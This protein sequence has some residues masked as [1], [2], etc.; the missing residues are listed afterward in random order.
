M[1]KLHIG[2]TYPSPPALRPGPAQATTILSTRPPWVVCLFSPAQFDSVDV[3]AL[4]PP[5]ISMRDM[6]AVICQPIPRTPA[7]HVTFYPYGQLLLFYLLHIFAGPAC[8]AQRSQL[9]GL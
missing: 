6:A 7:A 9:A 4:H 2:S 1:H 5:R 3:C 8:R